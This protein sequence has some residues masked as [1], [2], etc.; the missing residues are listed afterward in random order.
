VA[1]RIAARV[2][3]ALFLVAGAVQ[4]ARGQS[5]ERLTVESF[6][7]NA[8]TRSPRIDVPFHLTVTLRVRERVAEIDNLNLPILVELELLGDERQTAAGPRGTLYRETIAV[9]AHRPGAIAIEPATLQAI[10]ARDGKPKEW[11]TNGLTLRTAG[12]SNA[13][14]GGGEAIVRLPLFALGVGAIALVALLIFVRGRRERP[15]PAPVLVLP[16]APAPMV[17]R[18]LRRQAQDALAVLRAERSRAAAVIV[19]TAIWRMVGATDGETLADVLRRPDAH[20]AAMRGLLIALERS[21]FTYEADLQAAI[22]DTC[23]ALER[24]IESAA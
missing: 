4:L 23:S 11:Y 17:E 6:E 2:A 10:D 3:A 9:V 19:R 20:D 18:S 7:L 8:D 16:S 5:L 21:A 12:S 1:R 24:Y 14:P 22:E 13:L 15:A